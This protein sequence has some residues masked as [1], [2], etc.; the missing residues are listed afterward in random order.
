MENLPDLKLDYIRSFFP[1]LAGEWVF[2]DNAGGSQTLKLVAD[3][4]ADYLLHSN[5]QHGASYQV[6]QKAQ[7]R[8]RTATETM[9]T[10]VNASDPQEIVMGIR[11]HGYFGQC[12]R[13]R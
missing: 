5:V 9:A 13:S 4:I 3:R 6:S 1:S 7:Q 11:N 8:V 2:M 10:L 12:L